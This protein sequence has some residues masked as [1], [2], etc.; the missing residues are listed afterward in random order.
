M[1]SEVARYQKPPAIMSE[2]FGEIDHEWRWRTAFEGKVAPRNMATSHLFF[3]LRM[4][5]NNHMPARYAVGRRIRY[6]SFSP[7]SH[8]PEYL[9]EAIQQIGAELFTR[10]DLDADKSKQLKQMA[11]YFFDRLKN[12]V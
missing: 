2:V 6:Y 3:T 4:I 9:Q 7:V 1:G 8:P 11:S 12:D 5:W 10:R